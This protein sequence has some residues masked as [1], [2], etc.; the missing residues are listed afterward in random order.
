MAKERS[1]ALEKN[2]KIQ[3]LFVNRLQI[4]TFSWGTAG[5]FNKTPAKDFN[6]L[7]MCNMYN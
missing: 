6:Y 3:V 7:K 2:I 5:I 4:E 1:R